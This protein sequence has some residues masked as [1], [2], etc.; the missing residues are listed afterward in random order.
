M[1]I[2]TQALEA[3]FNA[4]VAAVGALPA[5]MGLE[6]ILGPGKARHYAALDHLLTERNIRGRYKN[7]PLF[8]LVTQAG[9]LLLVRKA[10]ILASEASLTL[11]QSLQSKTGA[12][13][14]L[15]GDFFHWDK[16]ATGHLTVLA[17]KKFFP[18]TA[19]TVYARTEDVRNAMERLITAMKANRRTD[20]SLSALQFMHDSN[21]TLELGLCWDPSRKAIRMAAPCLIQ[22]VTALIP[23]DR[24]V[25]IR[26]DSEP[27]TVAFHANER[28][29]G[30]VHA[31]PAGPDRKNNLQGFA[32]A[33]E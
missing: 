10:R 30:I 11:T 12:A 18:R 2:G 13:K 14:R 5:A 21:P 24:I 4:R 3:V 17:R 15:N 19:P 26:W 7:G 8:E 9:G 32:I 1:E 28:D 22:A 25:T 33:P 29:C 23:Q 6:V 31:R 20:A 16:P 27:H